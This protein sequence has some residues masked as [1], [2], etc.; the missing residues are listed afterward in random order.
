MQQLQI[1]LAALLIVLC[2]LWSP[3]AS[4]A[5]LDDTNWK[6]IFDCEF[7]SPDDLKKWH[8]Q[9]QT[10]KNYNHELSAYV[11]DAFKVKNGCLHITAQKRN[12]T[13]GGKMMHYTSG[14]LNT[15]GMFDIQYGRFDIRLTV[16]A[17]KGYWPAFW[18]LP[19]SGKWP[20]EIDF[21]EVLGHQPNRMYFTNHWATKTGKHL[22]YSRH[23]D[24][25]PD[26]SKEFHVITGIWT[27]KKIDYYVNEKKVVT[28]TTEI[29][30]EKMYM[31]LNLAV[32]GDWPGSPDAKTTFPQDMVVDYVRVYKPATNR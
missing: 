26:Y 23:F 7:D 24:V 13:Y 9:D 31:L 21:L 4:G 6:M 12:A 25:K 2:G 28:S 32:G 5:E 16:P 17:G 29:P 8:K 15:K 22:D 1:L 18:L 27:D 3:G 19:S 10:G 14:L 30:H 11:T 20:P